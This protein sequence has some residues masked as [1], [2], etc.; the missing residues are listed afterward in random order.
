MDKEMLKK[1]KGTVIESFYYL[2]EY[3]VRVLLDESEI[4]KIKESYSHFC[5]R[6]NKSNYYLEQRLR[7]L[8][9]A[10]ELAKLSY[11]D[12]IDVLSEVLQKKNNKNVER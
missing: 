9:E 8:N 6:A 7:R 2:L 10:I 1:N 11:P 12:L 5:K 3:G 4:N